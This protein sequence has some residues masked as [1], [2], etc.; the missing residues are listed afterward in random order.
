MKFIVE[1][2]PFSYAVDWSKEDKIENGWLNEYCPSVEE[3]LDAVVHLLGC[4]F[5][6]EKIE[7]EMRKRVSVE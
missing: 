6:E 2:G 7:Q 5:P 4:V 1:D 3:A